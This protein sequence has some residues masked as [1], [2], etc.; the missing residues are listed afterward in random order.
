MEERRRRL[1]STIQQLKS[2]LDYLKR[3]DG[4]KSQLCPVRVVVGMPAK[5]D[6][7]NSGTARR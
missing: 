6:S 1:I 5:H 2:E 4:R 7:T 3:W